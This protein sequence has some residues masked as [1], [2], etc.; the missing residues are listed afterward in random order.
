MRV[1]ILTRHEPIREHFPSSLPRSDF[2]MTQEITTKIGSSNQLH[3]SMI[4]EH[5]RSISTFRIWDGG[6]LREPY[7]QY[8]HRRHR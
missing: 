3:A 5:N 7:A 2:R 8:L 1:T 4:I 6:S